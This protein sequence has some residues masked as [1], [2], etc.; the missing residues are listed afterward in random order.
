[1]VRH[2]M[3]L[4]EE[5]EYSAYTAHSAPASNNIQQRE[6]LQEESSDPV[7]ANSVSQNPTWIP[8]ELVRL[9]PGLRPSS[10]ARRRM[11]PPGLSEISIQ[12]APHGCFIRPFGFVRYHKNTSHRADADRG[13]RECCG[14]A[15]THR[16]ASE[17]SEMG[18]AA[19]ANGISIPL[20]LSAKSNQTGPFHLIILSCSE[21]ELKE[22]R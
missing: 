12:D 14:H 15:C 7:K 6:R 21:G 8:S 3:R 22:F 16:S 17:F 13:G 18:P 11:L 9:L 10:H 19:P 5:G 1:M 2:L 4:S 20:C